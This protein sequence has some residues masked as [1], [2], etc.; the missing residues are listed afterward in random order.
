MESLRGDS[1][2]RL[3]ED[4]HK[5]S[6]VS[7]T[8]TGIEREN[9]FVVWADRNDLLFWRGSEAV[10][11]E[12]FSVGLSSHPVIPEGRKRPFRPSLGENEPRL[13]TMAPLKFGPL[14]NSSAIKV[15]PGRSFR[16]SET[17]LGAGQSWTRK[18]RLCGPVYTVWGSR[19]FKLVI[20]GGS[21]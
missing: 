10:L 7:R 14:P 11:R 8:V 3:S 2:F 1:L 16:I 15:A 20:I 21:T 4:R 19:D 17:G 18:I 13:V 6:I 9:I 5:H 12:S